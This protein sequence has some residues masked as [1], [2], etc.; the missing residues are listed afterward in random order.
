MPPND[1]R[2]EEK[3]SR[4]PSFLGFTHICGTN[5]TTGK[6]TVHRQTIGKRMAAKLKE[7]R[8]KLRQRMHTSPKETGKWLAQVVRGYFHRRSA[9]RPAGGVAADV[10]RGLA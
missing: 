7:L 10:P 6:F 4:K 1:G 2:S 5:H 9:R 8:A 3:R